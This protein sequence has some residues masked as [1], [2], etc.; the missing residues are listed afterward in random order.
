MSANLAACFS[1]KETSWGTPQYLFDQLSAEFGPFDLDAAADEYNHKCEAYYDRNTDALSVEE[2]N[3]KRI[4][5]NPPYGRDIGKWVEKAEEQAHIYRKR[6]VLLL[7]ARTDTRWWHKYIEG[8]AEVVRFVKGRLRFE[9]A[10]SSAPFPSVVV[11][12]D[13][14]MRDDDE[15]DWGWARRG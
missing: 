10:K 8:D 6:V 2:W 12:F 4:W 14:D 1:S 15:E 3:G 5:L 9:G 13:G 7:P 11:V